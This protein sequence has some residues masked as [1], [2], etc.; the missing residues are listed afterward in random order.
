VRQATFTKRGPTRRLN[1]DEIALRA[2]LD[3]LRDLAKYLFWAAES[4]GISLF[5]LP[6]KETGDPG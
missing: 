3:R 4:L 6:D 2:P 5:H 1:K